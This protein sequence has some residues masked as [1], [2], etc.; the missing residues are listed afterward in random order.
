M[1]IPVFGEKMADL[2][3][4]K[5]F[6]AYI[7]IQSADNSRLLLVQAPNGAYFLPGGEIEGDETQEE[8]L[9]REAMEELGY[10]IEV[11]AYLGQADEFFYSRHRQTAFHN[12]G[13]FYVA[14]SW[15]A[16]QAPLETFNHLEW[17]PVSEAIDRLKRGSHKWAVVQWQKS[18]NG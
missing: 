11:G 5:R 9:H 12:P 14:Q 8:T 15:Q 16:K 4:Q 3:Y 7:I 10:V 13:Y 1:D 18:L 2:V 17:F 6:A